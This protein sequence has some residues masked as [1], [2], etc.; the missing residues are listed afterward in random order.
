MDKFV[1]KP[2][3]SYDIL[4]TE[5]WLN[6]MSNKGYSLKRVNFNLR[7][8]LFEKLE[9][10]SVYYRI[11]YSKHI[12]DY[13]QEFTENKLYEG[14]SISNKFYIMKTN[15]ESPELEP[16]YNHLLERNK[17]IKF[18]SGNILLVEFILYLFPALLILLAVFGVLGTV[19]VESGPTID[20]TPENIGEIITGIISLFMFLGYWVVNIWMV[21]SFLKLRKSNSRLEEICG[22][23]LDLSFTIPKDTILSKK[24]IRE[25]RREKKLKKKLKLAWFYAPDKA[26]KWLDKMESQGY[27]LVQ[28]SRL[29][30]SFYFIK[31]EPKKVKYHV[32]FQKNTD[33]DYFNMNKEAGWK[34]FF[35][36]LTRFFTLSVWA[37]EYTESQPM[38]YSDSESKIKHARTYAIYYSV[39]FFPVSIVV[40]ASIIINIDVI[41]RFDNFDL[42]SF[43][44]LIPMILLFI[45]FNYFAIL[46][47]KYYL[48]V[49]N[50][51]KI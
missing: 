19:T 23:S 32:D 50:E 26:E 31:G 49:K 40:L 28:M 39:I 24:R 29:G 34:L 30:S 3:W 14:V 47:I 9:P 46:T 35:T 7:I 25:L 1:F 41:I 16:S 12:N 18:V 20:E 6:H 43:V 44:Y 10:A 4:K 45:E 17:R 13:P 37:H 8:F 27:H 22:D 5:K 42:F 33:S 21:Y 11:A 38:F 2:F 36:S 15:I 48:R 51:V